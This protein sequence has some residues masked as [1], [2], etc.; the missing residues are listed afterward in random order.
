[1]AGPQTGRELG[2][3][4]RR[5]RDLRGA[6]SG[7]GAGGDGAA[8]RAV[9]GAGDRRLVELAP[10]DP[11]AGRRAER[12]VTTAASARTPVD[13]PLRMVLIGPES[14]GKTWLTGRLVA[15]F[16]LPC[17]PEAAREFA[18]RLGRLLTADEIHPVARRQIEL[19]E[20]AIAAARQ[21]GAPAVLHDTDLVATVVYGDH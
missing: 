11:G 3:L 20:A 8:L 21:A 5:R 6:L 1:A 10:R 7:Q 17:S 4:D 12:A 15:E 18:E 14:T 16:G 13:R 2:D 19:E 9:R